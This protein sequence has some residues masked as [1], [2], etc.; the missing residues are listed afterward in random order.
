MIERFK[1][2]YR[3]LSNFAPA[4]V[5]FEEFDYRSVEHAYVASKTLLVG[6][7]LEVRSLETAGQAKQFGKSI[8]LRSDWEKV[9]LGIMLDL[10]R[11]KFNIPEYRDL[12]LATG[13]Q[14]IIEGNVWHDN[15]WGSCICN[16]CGNKGKNNLGKLILKIREELKQPQMFT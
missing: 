15:W 1:D 12:L 6:I 3:W 9:R 13:T 7:R 2:E 4:C 8:P 14:D 5:Q 16:S 11:Q 10:L